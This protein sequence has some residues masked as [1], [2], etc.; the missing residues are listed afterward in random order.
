MRNIYANIDAKAYIAGVS[1][2]CSKLLVLWY[3][4]NTK[5]HT[6]GN[7]AR[8]ST[9]QYLL[10]PQIIHHVSVACVPEIVKGWG[11]DPLPQHTATSDA[12]YSITY[13][14]AMIRHIGSCYNTRA[15]L[16]ITNN[17]AF[18]RVYRHLTWATNNSSRMLSESYS[19][20]LLNFPAKRFNQNINLYKAKVSQT[21]WH[22]HRYHDI[23]PK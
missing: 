1:S 22:R 18:T 5:L 12:G 4:W 6:Q 2:T 19:I 7:P 3:Y 15:T 10:R 20:L 11:V 23:E 14:Q 16:P 8:C 9:S 17:I 13:N 21:S